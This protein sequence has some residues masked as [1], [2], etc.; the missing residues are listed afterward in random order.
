MVVLPGPVIESALA[1]PITGDLL[2]TDVGLFPSADHHYVERGVGIRSAI[3]IFCVRGEGWAEVRGRRWAVK[4][5]MCLVLPPHQPHAY[6]ADM[7]RPWTIYWC[8]ATG[9]G[10]KGLLEA[11]G[12]YEGTP[13]VI[14]NESAAVVPLFERIMSILKTSY[15]RSSLLAASLVMG[16][17]FGELIAGQAA[18][19]TPVNVHQRLEQIIAYMRQQVHT[20]VHLTE[21]AA[22][23][24]LSPS[25]FA[26][27]FK[28][29]TGYPV[30]DYFARMKIQAACKMLDLTEVPINVI[31]A[32]L[33]YA[34][35]LYFSRVFRRVM[36][37]SPKSYRSI[38]KG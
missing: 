13:N 37:I 15:D 20:S 30:L 16:H 27:V 1:R 4:E 25:H 2:P 9:K 21:L 17:L 6:G 10:L 38:S 36:A 8:H 28:R 22:M 32:R 3:L 14:S 7:G 34:D 11:V 5:K 29:K 24:H 26:A 19:A 23:A 18:A 31:A 35:A 12:V 33:G